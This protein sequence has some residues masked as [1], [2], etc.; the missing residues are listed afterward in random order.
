MKESLSQQHI[1]A[2]VDYRIQRA[3]ETI[4]EIPYLMERTYYNTAVNRMYY[5]CYYAASALLAKHRIE[6]VTHAGV[7][8]MLGMHFVHTEKLS[9]EYNRSY[10]LLFER[11]HSN[12]YDDFAYSTQEEI[13]ELLPK[14]E[15]LIKA[16]EKL[17][18]ES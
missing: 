6:A 4:A 16:I 10:S 11:R 9:R 17:I 7:K 13:T 1:D 2:L 14:A 12:D 3:H 5:A 15:A 8:Q 18:A